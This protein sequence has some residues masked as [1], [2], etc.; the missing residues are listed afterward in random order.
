VTGATG[1]DGSQGVTGPTGAAGSQGVTGPTGAAGNTGAAGSTG[2]TGPQGPAG[3]GGLY[4][5]DSSNVSL[6]QV[7]G[8]Q[9][10]IVSVQTSGGYQILL[11]MN[12]EPGGVADLV[13]FSNSNCTGTPYLDDSTGAI[14]DFW[15]PTY[16][17]D[18]DGTY[19]VPISSASASIASTEPSY[20]YAGQSCTTGSPQGTSGSAWQLQAV[21]P[22]TVGIPASGSIGD[23]TIAATQ[24]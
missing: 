16:V 4:A 8:Y 7:I 10:N 18:D 11:E 20:E 14:G 5:W 2:P 3:S 22:A 9:E 1:A 17:V 13:Y 15:S 21:S 23:I 19:Y 24:P 6:G 12:G